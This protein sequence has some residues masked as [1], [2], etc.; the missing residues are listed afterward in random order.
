MYN[1]ILSS[2]CVNTSHK[3][4]PHRHLLTHRLTTNFRM[5]SPCKPIAN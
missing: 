4:A 3:G 2:S 5:L 1:I